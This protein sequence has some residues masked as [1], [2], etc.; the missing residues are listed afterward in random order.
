MQ[1]YKSRTSMS[2]G[3]NAASIKMS[4]PSSSKPLGC[5]GMTSSTHTRDFTCTGE[6]GSATITINEGRIAQP[7]TNAQLHL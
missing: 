6:A 3:F 5:E 2:Q 4:Y 7:V 1:T